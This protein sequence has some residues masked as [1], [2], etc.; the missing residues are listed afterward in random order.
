[1]KRSEL[2][3]ARDKLNDVRVQQGCL[4]RA[5]GSRVRKYGRFSTDARK[6]FA[7]EQIKQSGGTKGSAGN[8]A[9]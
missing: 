1:M 8:D 2:G 4:N 9:P 5:F 3:Q 7:G 6:L